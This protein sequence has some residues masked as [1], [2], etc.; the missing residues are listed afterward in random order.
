MTDSYRFEA[1]SV[2]AKGSK[3]PPWVNRSTPWRAWIDV[4]GGLPWLKPRPYLIAEERLAELR[5]KL[6]EMGFSVVEISCENSPDNPER[7]FLTELTR[8]LRLSDIG[9]GN[10]DTFN[11]RLWDFL[12]IQGGEPVAL[13]ILDLDSL[14]RSD[15][16]S[17]VRCVH[18]L[19]SLTEGAGL[20]DSAADRQI[21]Y[22]FVGRWERR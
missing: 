4:M 3:P 17:F 9:A 12:R 10:W 7:T 18:N 8:G 2:D 6:P 13:V 21:E 19:L 5:A 14:L 16:H 11:D 1:P 15:V 20:A 22:F